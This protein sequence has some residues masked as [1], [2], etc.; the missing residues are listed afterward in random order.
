MDNF[1]H[2]VLERSKGDGN[3][4]AI[5]NIEPIATNGISEYQWV[6]MNCGF[7]NNIYRLKEVDNDQTFK[8]SKTVLLEVNPDLNDIV[9]YPMPVENTLYLSGKSLAG[10]QIQVLNALGMVVDVQI[11][12]Q[13]GTVS[14]DLAD[15]PNGF[16]FYQV[17]KNGQIVGG[18]SFIRDKR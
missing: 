16:Y 10:A 2:F 18:Q 15:L 4:T 13:N 12:N 3:W 1:S 14:I 11:E 7:G 17:I 8:Y 6:D 5:A 9:A